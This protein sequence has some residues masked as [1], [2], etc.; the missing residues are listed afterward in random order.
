MEAERLLEVMRSDKKARAGSVHY[1]LPRSI[2]EMAG[3]ES[4]W[5]V[6]VDDAIVREVLA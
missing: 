4:G 2:G 5:T 1:A 6:P 3:S